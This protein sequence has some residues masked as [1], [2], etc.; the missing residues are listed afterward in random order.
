MSAQLP[1][2][3]PKLTS[4]DALQTLVENR[5]IYN[6]EHCELNIFETYEH[7]QLVPLKFTDLVVTSMLRGKKVMHLFDQE[8]FDYIPGETVLVPANELMKIDF[9]EAE[10]ENPTQCL[11]L[12]I[13][14][15]K[16]SETLDFLNERY[17]KEG[18]NHYWSLDYENF[19]FK[20][21]HE[22]N[23]L[24]HKVIDIC[25]GD[26]LFKD[27]LADLALQELLVKI[28]QLQ[29]LHASEKSSK[30][31]NPY[32][33]AVIIEINK[34]LYDKIKLEDLA[35]HV[36]MSMSSLYRLFKTELGISPMEYLILAKIKRAKH[37]LS[38]QHLYIKNIAFEVG[39][40]DPNYFNRIFKKYEGI[41]PK[42]YQQ[43]N[44]KEG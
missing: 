4:P 42:Q 24:L 17:P 40:E 32:L 27:T 20:N 28:I 5:T 36:G 34:H 31:K 26:H 2:N 44:Q 10:H 18:N 35:K 13:D 8:G 11:A 38:Q 23:Q 22:M 29:N 14:H 15:G 9:P 41:T 16:I 3:L 6:L 7:A 39:F 43:I 37:F 1:I 21:N 25:Q 12:A 30:V 19:F 33:D